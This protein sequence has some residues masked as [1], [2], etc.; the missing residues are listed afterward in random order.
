[1]L[2]F[3]TAVLM[4]ASGEPHPLRDNAVRLFRDVVEGRAA[5]ATTPEVLQ[6]Y[7][8]VRA[9]R[10]SRQDALAQVE[11]F[12]RILSPLTVVTP[13]DVLDGLALWVATPSLGAF[14]SVLAAVALRTDTSLVSSDKAFAQVPGLDWVDLATY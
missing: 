9:R 7:A 3:D 13:R 5:A 8:H 4:Y 2:I 14:D 12:T 6:E 1:M 11:H 10:R